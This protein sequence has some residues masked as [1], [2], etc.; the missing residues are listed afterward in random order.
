MGAPGTTE[1]VRRTRQHRRESLRGLAKHHGINP[2]TV[3]KWKKRTSVQD[4]RTG[5]KEPRSTVLKHAATAHDED[6]GQ[7]SGGVTA[8]TP[9]SSNLQAGGPAAVSVSLADAVFFSAQTGQRLRV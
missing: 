8:T 5:P 9:G 7:E 4:E 3:A 6:E 1:A 2:K